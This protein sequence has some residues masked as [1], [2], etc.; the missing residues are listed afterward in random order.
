V[1]ITGPG[2]MMLGSPTS[3][4]GKLFE[5]ASFDPVGVASGVVVEA[6]VLVEGSGNRSREIARLERLRE[7]AGIL[8][9]VVRGPDRRRCGDQTRI[10]SDLDHSHCHCLRFFCGSGAAGPRVLPAFSA[11]T[12]R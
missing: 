2:A 7:D 11:A 6:E 10:R 3:R 8:Q 12:E 1:W 4:A 5:C 9:Q